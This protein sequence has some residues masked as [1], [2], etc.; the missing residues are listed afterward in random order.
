[1]KFIF[2]KQSRIYL[3]A[4]LLL[5]FGYQSLAQTSAP[6]GIFADTVYHSVLLTSDIVFGDNFNPLLNEEDTL[7]LDTYE[8]DSTIDYLR[9]VI[10]YVHGGGFTGGD[11]TT[12][13]AATFG[14]YFAKCGYL[15]A[16]INYRLYIDN[17][18][19]TIDNFQVVYMGTQD[20]KSAVRFFRKHAI[21]YCVD[22]S[23]IFMIG[24]SAGASLCLSAAYWNQSEADDI[25]NTASFGPLENS[26][27]NEGYSSHPDAI[28][29]CWGGIPDTAWLQNETTPNQLFHGTADPVVPYVWGLAQNG[30]YLFGSYTIH[31][32]SLANSIESYLHPFAGAGHGVGS[33]SP[34]FDTLVQIATAF[35]Y[36]HVNAGEGSTLCNPTG[37]DQSI[38]SSDLISVSTLNDDIIFIRNNRSSSFSGGLKIYSI[39]GMIVSTS[40]IYIPA[41]AVRQVN[42][43]SLSAGCYFA[44]VES[45]KFAMTLK[46][47]IVRH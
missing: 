22:T 9:P 6:P 32:A 47:L 24:T 10:I 13:K 8:P 29:S 42:G 37:L 36:D 45:E 2:Q 17:G 1:M 30:V 43:L 14:N 40:K 44:K 20:A 41:N 39:S 23:K 15:C 27:G 28:V 19:D 7:K 35:F 38:N 18:Q 3:V 31:E 25:F 4:F 33:N 46:I 21:E 12:D 16:S 11:K 34:Q 26:S 5:A